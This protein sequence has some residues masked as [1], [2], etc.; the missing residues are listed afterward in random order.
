MPVYRT[1]EPIQ[2]EPWVE[3]EYVRRVS[4]SPRAK[5]SIELVPR[6]G[7]PKELVV[8]ASGSAYIETDCGRA[9]YQRGDWIVVPPGGAKITAL[10]P[11]ERGPAI[12]IMQVSG[13]WESL[14]SV[15]LIHFEPD[16]EIEL[17]FHDYHEYWIMLRGER[18]ATTEGIDHDLRPGDVVATKTGDDHA[19]P[20]APQVIE[21]IA[22]STASRGRGRP[23]HLHP[24]IDERIA[25]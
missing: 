6:P 19:M 4:L 7:G 18:P 13:R 12:E 3:L 11:F 17:H 2:G 1:E 14:Q 25:P 9:T 15:N 5:P 23:G 10:V 21:A 22:V 8:V 16:G 24:G 20:P